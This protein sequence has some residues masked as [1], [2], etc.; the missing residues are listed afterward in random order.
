MQ[1]RFNG[2]GNDPTGGK[3]AIL[4]VL[5]VVLE[6]LTVT[7]ARNVDRSA[8]SNASGTN[9]SVVIP[10]DKDGNASISFTAEVDLARYFD[11]PVDLD[12]VRWELRDDGGAV[13]Q[14]GQYRDVA[15]IDFALAEAASLQLSAWYDYDI[16]GTLNGAEQ[17]LVV[18][19]EATQF[20]SLRVQSAGNPGNAITTALGE[21]VKTIVV[22]PEPGEVDAAIEFSIE[23]EGADLAD[24]DTRW[25]FI[26]PESSIG[27]EFGADG[28]SG[29]A[30]SR[31][32]ANYLLAVGFDLD[33]NGQLSIEEVAIES[34]VVVLNEGPPT[35]PLGDQVTFQTNQRV[36]IH[37][38]PLPDASPT[39]DGEQDRMPDMAHLDAFSL[40]PTF[41]TT[42]VAVPVPGGELALDFRR[43]LSAGTKTSVFLPQ[44]TGGGF[45]AQARW[46]LNMHYANYEWPTETILGRG[47]SANLGSRAVKSYS[48]DPE[49]GHPATRV[50]VYDEVGAAAAFSLRG[51]KYIPDVKHTFSNQSLRGTLETRTDGVLGFVYRKTYGT[52]L[53]FEG[54][55]GNT[56]DRSADSAAADTYYR[57]QKIVD[58]NGNTLVYEYDP[59]DDANNP[60]AG[61]AGNTFVSRIYDPST[62]GLA[63]PRELRFEYVT[64][65]GIADLSGYD[66]VNPYRL[67]KV[68]D[69]LGREH[70][71]TY[72]QEGDAN[73]GDGGSVAAWEIGQL[74][75]VTKPLVLGPNGVEDAPTVTF[76]YGSVIAQRLAARTNLTSLQTNI[77]TTRWYLPES[78]SSLGLETAAT[79]RHTTDFT[80]L[81]D[82]NGNI[83]TEALPSFIESYGGAARSVWENKPI[84]TSVTTDDGTVDLHLV[85]NSG[86]ESEAELSH[87]K[88]TTEITDTRG[89]KTRYEFGAE[90]VPF[91]NDLEFAIAVDEVTRTTLDSPTVTGA[92]SEYTVT[93]KYS[94]DLH[95]NLVS[96]TDMSG[97]VVRYE[98]NSGEAGDLF[99]QQVY[100]GLPGDNYYEVFGQPSRSILADNDPGL[101]IATKYRYDT[102]FNKLVRQVDAEG[103]ATTFDLDEFGNRIA[104]H[105]AVDTPVQADSYFGFDAE[106]DAPGTAGYDPTGFVFFSTD[107]DG[108][109]TESRTNAYGHLEHS[110][111]K[112]RDDLGEDLTPLDGTS[113]YSVID[114]DARWIVTRRV[115]D[116]PGTALIDEGV[117]D[118]T[119][120][121]ID[122]TGDTTA[123]AYDAWNRVIETTPV[124]VADPEGLTPRGV[125]SVYDFRGNA[126]KQTDQKGN[127]SVTF[128][129]RLN[130]PTVSVFDLDGDAYY[131]SYLGGSAAP[132]TVI[133]ASGSFVA[134]PGDIVTRTTYDEAGLAR[135]STDARGHTTTN[136]Y[137]ELLRLTET[138]LPPVTLADGTLQSNRV[139]YEYG[140]N[141]G[142]GAFTFGGFNPTR[143]IDARGFATDTVYDAAYRAIRTTQRQD[144]GSG[145]ASDA[146][147]R[148]GEPTTFTTYNKVHN[149]I[150]V[151]V[152]NEASDGTTD[153]TQ[154]VYTYYDHRHRPTVQAVDMTGNGT[155]LVAGTFVDAA[156]SFT[157]D[158]TDLIS[159]TAYDNAG[160]ARFVTDA[161]GRVTE[162]VFDGAGRATTVILPAVTLYDPDTGLSPGFS[163]TTTT[164]Y[165]ADG[166][167]ALTTDAN[168]NA[169][170]VYYDARNRPVVSVLDLDGDASFA[171]A[172]GSTVTDALA[173]PGEDDD[174]YDV[175]TRTLYDLN[176]NVYATV[177][178]RG[179]RADLRYDRADRQTLALAPAVYD[180]ENGNTLTRPTT[181]TAYDKNSNVTAVTDPRGVVTATEYDQWNRAFRVTANAAA[182][183]NVADR[184]VTETLY[185]ANGNALALTLHNRVPLSGGGGVERPQTTTY[186]YD[187]Y[188]RQLT[189][190]LPASASGGGDG[191]TRTSTTAYDRVSNVLS[192]TDPKGQ[193][194]ESDYDRAN[195]ATETRLRRAD[196]TVEETRTNQYDRVGNLLASTDLHGSTTYTY[197]D[198][199]RQLT[200]TRNNAPSA[201]GDAYTVTSDYDPNGNRTRV[202]YPETGRVLVSRYDARNLLATVADGP[203]VS[204]YTYDLAGNRTGLTRPDGTTD[205]HFD[206]LNR[207]ISMS[208]QGDQG[209]IYDQTYGYDLAGN[210]VDVYEAWDADPDTSYKYTTYTYDDLYR[211]TDE[212]YALFGFAAPAPGTVNSTR[213][214]TYDQAGNRLTETVDGVAT[215]YTY[216]DLNQLLTLSDGTTY[217]YDPNGNRITKAK[218]A[219]A[220]GPVVITDYYYDVANRLT[221]ADI[222]GTEAFAATYDARTRRLSKTEG[223][224]T[225]TFRYDA[226]VSFQEHKN[227]DLNVEFVR[228]SGMGGGIG[229][230]LYRDTFNPDGSFRGREF[231][232]YNAVGHTVANTD[233]SGGVTK[234]TAYDAFGNVVAETGSSDNNRLANTKERDASIGLDNHGFRYYDPET[235]RYIT[236]D[237]IGYADGLNN[238]LHVHNNPVNHIDPL[239]LESDWHHQ[240]AKDVFD[241]MDNQS[242]LNRLNLKLADDIDIHSA[243]YGWMLDS[244]DHTGS[245]GVHSVSNKVKQGWNTRQKQWLEGIQEVEGKGTVITK[246]RLDGFLEGMRVDFG[247]TR[248]GA[249]GDEIA[250]KGSMADKGYSRLADHMHDL[251]GKGRF[252]SEGVRE[253]SHAVL[254]NSLNHKSGTLAKK[255]GYRGA[256][257]WVSHKLLSRLPLVGGI[258]SF[259]IARQAG[260]S[261]AEAAM[262]GAAGVLLPIDAMDVGAATE[263]MLRTTGAN[264]AVQAASRVYES[265]S[266]QHLIDRQ[267]STG[268]N[269]RRENY[270][271]SDLK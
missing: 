153:A 135:T 29:L 210:R 151:Q 121:D 194:V 39:G 150:R 4:H 80:Y 251:T 199:N 254:E 78:I 89:V 248:L 152:L 160:N 206:A 10:L 245:G 114:P 220:G 102:T 238:Y 94:T 33:G 244:A 140:P 3:T 258:F 69:P 123:H 99:N 60:V 100:S 9:G 247:L 2:E 37:G 201:G 1:A 119:Y 261:Y 50:T 263:A 85:T 38:V 259:T 7:D 234:T 64:V 113:Y 225:T 32:G 186:T 42:D 49:P 65:A 271:L 266:Q 138:D 30:F 28:E 21:P 232:H 182:P 170:A 242:D 23:L 47:W 166:L 219:S 223:S 6:T 8:T 231:F 200:E 81:E 13:L 213:A 116:D 205:A 75:S 133:T 235:G 237:P 214:Y 161:E 118:L 183:A 63:I 178:P 145:L 146:A 189:Q 196:N 18:A 17:E 208:T 171:L 86:P 22:E 66:T 164:A 5:P 35:I 112:G 239:G 149:P 14:E 228:G 243:E 59:R 57:L 165:N 264:D 130:R 230:I 226:G 132:G 202:T 76:D 83:S 11:T 187:P 82:G 74:K 127:T 56:Q 154:N 191:L 262:N 143:V 158:A 236:R 256:G 250:V 267:E 70:S 122:P 117:L 203:T 12:R 156:G 104:M 270:D 198:L 34:Y 173:F 91:N 71:Y 25:V 43:T 174:N 227:G 128:Y 136:T 212:T 224:D 157:G 125:T 72:F 107:P 175:T 180:A 233:A 207:V 24:V 124:A 190:T 155:G 26:G 255:V 87:T 77:Y 215:G 55:G 253:T 211:L 193:S 169:S 41:G 44:P 209:L 229:S 68:I 257:K 79:D 221:S 147:A 179:N 185:D 48:P 46:V 197:D 137:D 131:G 246:E 54:F 176:G 144:S 167:A 105:E 61:R 241:P 27:D 115:T 218:P 31:L 52:E 129:D 106:G 134:D 148:P 58:R 184:T 67:G 19:V 20:E 159:R 177:D 269:I 268:T 168:G 195:R 249:D 120:R 98:Y 260:A 108:R 126:V 93:Y 181:T 111:I 84:L 97:N 101:Q 240:A 88:R 204:T 265:R 96:V 92:G 252:T 40:L 172:P 142:S 222:D 45:E 103:V 192:S 36:D 73:P 62:L 163:P 141:S 95:G 53:Y 51:G 16:S 162:T 217:A 90:I 188:N 109:V 139:R 216:D 110:I 15:S